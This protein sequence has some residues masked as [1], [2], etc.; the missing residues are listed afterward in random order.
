MSFFLTTLVAVG[1]LFINPQ[2]SPTVENA[3]AEADRTFIS[4]Y[5]SQYNP[6]AFRRNNNCGPASLAMALRIFGH[7]GSGQTP[8]EAVMD[9]R[10]DMTGNMADRL[11]GMRDVIRGARANG[12]HAYIARTMVQLDSGLNAGDVAVVSGSPS[13]DT[14]YGARL[15]YRHTNGGHFILINK[16]VGADSYIMSDPESADGAYAINGKELSGFINYYDRRHSQ[17]GA[18]MVGS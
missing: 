10:K 7:A 4:Q 12:L 2:A 8:Q 17:H 3:I 13:T 9:A 5:P 11:T 1:A 6:D 14:S 16:K 18:V 15:K